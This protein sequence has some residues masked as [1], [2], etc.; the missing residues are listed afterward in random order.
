MRA[1]TESR[2]RSGLP[3]GETIV[4]IDP[5]AINVVATGAYNPAETITGDYDYIDDYNLEGTSTYKWYL[6]DDASGTGKAQISSETSTTYTIDVADNGKF[7]SFEVTPVDSE[8]NAGDPVESSLHEITNPVWTSHHDNTKWQW[9]SGEIGWSSG[10]SRWEVE[11]ADDGS[12]TNQGTIEPIGTWADGFR[13]TQCRITYTLEPFG[14]GYYFDVDEFVVSTAGTTLYSGSPGS[15]IAF[16]LSGYDGDITALT[17]SINS[18][19]MPGGGVIGVTN[20]EFYG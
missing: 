9:L 11:I 18:D 13:P 5:V 19:S 20:I 2:L 17:I 12:Y 1:T 15:G 4:D 7:I 8:G 10:D 3:P 6:N 16:N 14:S